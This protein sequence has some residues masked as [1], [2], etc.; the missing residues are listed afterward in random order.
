MFNSMDTNIVI[1]LLNEMD[2]LHEKSLKLVEEKNKWVVPR[3][4]IK[5]TKT[6]LKKK[7]NEVFAEI[8]PEIKRIARI[9][10]HIKLREELL[11]FFKD[12]SKENPYLKNFYWLVYRKID[13]YIARRRIL[14]SR[15]LLYLSELGENMSRIVEP[16][17]RSYIEY[18][19]MN[20]SISLEEKMDIIERIEKILERKIRFKDKNDRSIFFEIMINIRKY[21]PLTF[22]TDDDEFLKKGKRAY[23]NIVREKMFQESWFKIEKIDC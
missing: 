3:S 9:Q 5:E 16:A 12:L 10:D 14:D 15:M 22:Y 6:T 17:L 4:V 8:F 13:G 2:R 19:I 18:E 23:E 21:K 20:K 7:L 1:G 11:K